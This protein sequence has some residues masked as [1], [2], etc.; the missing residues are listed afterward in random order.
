[1]RRRSV[2][3]CVCM[4]VCVCAV[5]CCAWC[6]LCV[7]V[8]VRVRVCVFSVFACIDT[9][10]VKRMHLV[11]IAQLRHDLNGCCGLVKHHRLTS[12][13]PHAHTHAHAHAHT[14]PQ[15]TQKAVH[16]HTTRGKQ[17]RNRTAKTRAR[18][19]GSFLFDDEVEAAF[20]LI[21]FYLTLSQLYY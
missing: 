19:L 5:L 11:I 2:C 20:A 6:E 4:C 14:H 17:T 21:A 15:H 8:F 9:E 13:H 12:H 10:Q 3:V 16:M 7:F 1:M 18:D